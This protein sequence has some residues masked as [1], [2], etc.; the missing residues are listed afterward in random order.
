[1]ARLSLIQNKILKGNWFGTKP[2]EDSHFTQIKK[3]I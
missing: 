2:I 3:Y 1:M